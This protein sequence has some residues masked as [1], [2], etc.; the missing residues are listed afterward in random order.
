MNGYCDTTDELT[1]RG[2]SA[3]RSKG[4]FVD[5]WPLS[6]CVELCRTCARCF[7]VSYSKREG[8]CSW[9]RRCGRV[10]RAMSRTHTTYTLREPNGTFVDTRALLLRTAWMQRHERRQQADARR[11]R[12]D[13]TEWILERPSRAQVLLHEGSALSQWTHSRQPDLQRTALT[14]GDLTRWANAIRRRRSGANP[15]RWGRCVV[16]G[17]SASLLQTTR[18]L[19]Q[20]IDGHDA[21]IRVNRAPTRGFGASVGART[22][23]RVWGHLPLPDDADSIVHA[24]RW[25][26]RMRATTTNTSS[27]S[28]SA[29]STQ[30]EEILIYC[31]PTPWVGECWHDIHRHP[32][33]RVSPLAWHELNAAIQT[34]NATSTTKLPSTGAMAVWVA[35]GLCEAVSVAGFGN[36][37]DA[38][39]RRRQYA[40]HHRA[41]A[42]M[43][44]RGRSGG[45]HAAETEGAS[46]GRPSDEALT[47]LHEATKF[48]EPDVLSR[49]RA[50]T[51][52]GGRRAEP[53]PLPFPPSASPGSI[54]G[55]VEP[56]GSAAPV[57]YLDARSNA[58][59]KDREKAYHYH[60]MRA[61]WGWLRALAKQRIIST[62]DCHLE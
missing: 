45:R 30:Q 8:D 56:G 17:S 4:T 33:P 62:L 29:R 28:L 19:G 27:S 51:A 46:T 34:N 6:R 2:C 42:S 47:S 44:G 11:R 18:Q 36:G 48:M 15:L 38:A 13:R 7:H 22:T 59:D 57:Y 21:V 35:L 5:T 53:P 9:F 20:R 41:G 3:V 52:R 50:W 23:L 12:E 55:S 24:P 25:R 61:E 58:A 31:Q 14:P 37:C 16:V 32:R 60:D 39:V 26:D 1:E 49:I 10:Q 54:P 40:K 43:G